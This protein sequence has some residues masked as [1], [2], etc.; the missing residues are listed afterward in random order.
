MRRRIR[1]YESTGIRD[2]WDMGNVEFTMDNS[3]LRSPVT[4]K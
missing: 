3:G 1:E 4:E 2:K